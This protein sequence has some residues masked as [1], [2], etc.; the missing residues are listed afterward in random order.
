[1]VKKEVT[2][3][4]TRVLICG[5]RNYSNREAIRA[6]LGHLKSLGFKTIIEGGAKGAD[7]IAREEADKLG[8]KVRTFKAK[9]DPFGHAAGPIR[10][11]EMLDK[12]KPNL[13]IGFHDNIIESK[14]TK[15]MIT[16]AAERGIMVILMEKKEVI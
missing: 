16:Q 5:D 11:R 12:G 10:N 7:T 9:W 15:N 1:M 2:T 8:M 13:V 14:G 4:A 3:V 6:V